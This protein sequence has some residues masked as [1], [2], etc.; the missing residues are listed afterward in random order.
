MAS[1][2]SANQGGPGGFRE[3]M[4]RVTHRRVHTKDGTREEGEAK[5]GQVDAARPTNSMGDQTGNVRTM[6][7][8]C[9]VMAIA[10]G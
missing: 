6:V 8:S 4:R 3:R 5:K 9:V 1:T 2:S 10:P 7:V